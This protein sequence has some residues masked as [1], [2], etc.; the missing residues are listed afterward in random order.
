[1]IFTRARNLEDGVCTEVLLCLEYGMLSSTDYKFHMAVLKSPELP[2][3]C[4][5]SQEPR[6][7]RT[8]QKGSDERF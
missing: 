4:I 2:R 6:N 8:G 3:Q 1:M 7:S 5:N